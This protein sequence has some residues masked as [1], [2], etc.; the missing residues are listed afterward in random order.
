MWTQIRTDTTTSLSFLLVLVESKVFA[1]VSTDNMKRV[2]YVVCEDQSS[3]NPQT[4][5]CFFA[6]QSVDK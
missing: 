5:S 1:K 3:S 4:F 6:S 2:Q